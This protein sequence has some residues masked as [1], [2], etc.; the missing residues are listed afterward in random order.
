[1]SIRCSLCGWRWCLASGL[2]SLGVATMDGGRKGQ[3]FILVVLLLDGVRRWQESLLDKFWR[4]NIS[5]TGR[6]VMEKYIARCGWWRDECTSSSQETGPIVR[7]DNWWYG[8]D[9][10]VYV[11]GTEFV[12]ATTVYGIVE[13]DF[14]WI[15]VSIGVVWC[16]GC[17]LGVAWAVTTKMSG[18]TRSPG[19]TKSLGGGSAALRYSVHSMADGSSGT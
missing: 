6:W 16:F 17:G 2:S 10:G 8:L 12:W 14:G 7:G 5:M 3:L 4:C 18:G 11:E 9:K 1:M 19:G 13:I 15:V